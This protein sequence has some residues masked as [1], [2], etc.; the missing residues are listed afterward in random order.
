MSPS[1]ESIKT[2]FMATCERG[3]VDAVLMDELGVPLAVIA[4]NDSSMRLEQYFS[5]VT[6][7]FGNLF[8]LAVSSFFRVTR[9]NPLQKGVIQDDGYKNATSNF[10]FTDST[11]DSTIIYQQKDIYF[12]HSGDNT[13]SLLDNNRDSVCHCVWE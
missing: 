1:G 12:L 4:A 8:G 3:K 11:H 7:K 6:P 2:V 5:P 13:F 9:I 10:Y